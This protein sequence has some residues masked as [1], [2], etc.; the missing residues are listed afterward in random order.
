[1]VADHLGAC[2]D[3]VLLELLFLYVAFAFW[4]LCGVFVRVLPL[5]RDEVGVLL[6]EELLCTLQF[7]GVGVREGEQH[8]LIK[9]AQHTAREVKEEVFQFLVFAE[10]PDAARL[11]AVL[12]RA[13]TADEHLETLE[14]RRLLV[15]RQ[16]LDVREH[17]AHHLPELVELLS[18]V[19]L[20]VPRRALMQLALRAVQNHDLELALVPV[21]A[22]LRTVLRLFFLF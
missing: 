7:G 22:R 4:D 5:A 17:T 15:V 20:V 8:E 1:M 10:Q 11:V 14:G 9:G 18:E 16:H 2:T 12:E 21:R 13:H 6:V 19:R 3:L